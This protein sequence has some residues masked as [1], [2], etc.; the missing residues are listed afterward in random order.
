[1]GFNGARGTAAA[2]TDSSSE[3]SLSPTLFWAVTLKKYVS[4][5]VRALKVCEVTEADP[6]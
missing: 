3:S 5:F 2:R 1:V 6:V 4:P